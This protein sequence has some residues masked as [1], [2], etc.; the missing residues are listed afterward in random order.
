MLCVILIRVEH[1]TP[2]NKG[3]SILQAVKYGI[4]NK[5][6]NR[7]HSQIQ[8]HFFLLIMEVDSVTFALILVEY[9]KIEAGL[10]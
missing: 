8:D 2:A 10:K 5:F 1:R 9:S 4:K 7:G 3:S 6:L